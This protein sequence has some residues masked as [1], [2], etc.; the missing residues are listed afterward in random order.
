MV[1]LFATE[2][3]LKLQEQNLEA[4]RRKYKMNKIILKIFDETYSNL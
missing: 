4:M 3:Q 1:T 2:R